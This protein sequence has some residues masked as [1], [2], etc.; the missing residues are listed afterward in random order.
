M[1]PSILF[2]VRSLQADFPDIAQFDE[3]RIDREHD[4][5]RRGVENWIVQTYVRLRAPLEAAGFTVG[6]DDRFERGTICVAH[7]DDLNRYGDPLHDCF[8]IGAR[9]DRPR[10]GVANLEVVQNPLQLQS[11]RARLIPHWPQPGLVPRDPARGARIERAVYYGRVSA[12]P[13][14]YTDPAFHGALGELGVSLEIR[15]RGWND[16]RDVDLVFAHRDETTEMLANKPFSKLVNAWIA[17]APA[18]LAPEPAFESLRRGD[19]DFIATSDA[20]GTLAGVASLKASPERYRAMIENGR[21]RGAEYEVAAVRERWMELFV[22][23]AV[24]GFEQWRAHGGSRL[25]RYARFLVAMSAQKA[26]ARRF[27][28]SERGETPHVA[29]AG[30]AR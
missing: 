1:K 9:A 3:S 21:A 7:R 20:A 11:P 22:N 28:R 23:E 30:S 12:I 17:G 25:A 10:V 18:V 27:R 13:A 16:Y 6:I 19:L 5:F 4:R 29:G 24:P 14:W 2:V 15:E 8:V 26:E